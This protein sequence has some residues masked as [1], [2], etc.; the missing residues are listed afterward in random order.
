MALLSLRG[1]PPVQQSP[2][3]S[4]FHRGTFKVIEKEQWALGD[5]LEEGMRSQNS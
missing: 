3:V 5:A 2:I 1:L 4:I